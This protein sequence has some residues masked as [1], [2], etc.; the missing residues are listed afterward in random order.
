MENNAIKDSTEMRFRKAIDKFFDDL[1][2]IKS[3]NK[4]VIAVRA[5]A[6]M[7]HQLDLLNPHD[8]TP[9]FCCY[10]LKLDEKLEGMALSIETK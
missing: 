4:K 5:S 2:K 10:P 3:Q 9:V 6:E 8:Q 1:N 7:K